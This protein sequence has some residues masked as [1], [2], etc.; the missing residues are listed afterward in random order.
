LDA[1]T[2]LVERCL[3]A[4]LPDAVSHVM[5][6][7]ADRAALEADVNHLME[8]LPALAR[9]LRYGNVRRTDASSIEAVVD[10]LVVRICIGLPVAAS[11]LDDEAAAAMVARVMGVHESLAL[12]DRRDLAERWEAALAQLGGRASLHGLLSGR[13]TRLLLDAGAMPTGEV[14]RRMAATLS[15]GEEPARA[16]AWVEGFLSGSALILLHDRSLLGL[17]DSWLAGV[18][19]DIFD[20]VLPLLRRT[21]A[22][23]GQVER[24]QLGEHVRRLDGRSGV[25]EDGTDGDLDVAR[26]ELVVPVLA[27][28]LT[29]PK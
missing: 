29:V 11:S 22:T 14:S 23:F 21:F 15:V 4:E 16:A 17:V 3:L 19:D 12:L 26:A 18:D 28:L 6:V 7:L 20:D 9:A 8:A 10:G 2:G 25:T 13:C 24:R 1:L 27:R 5:G